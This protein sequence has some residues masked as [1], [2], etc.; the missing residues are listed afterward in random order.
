MK[1]FIQLIHP[2]NWLVWLAMGLL[3]LLTL[4]PF[5]LQLFIGKQ[6]GRLMYGL[7]PSRR[8]VVEI[9]ISLCFP[10][11]SRQEQR[12]LVK[13]NFYS[14]GMMLPE[15][16]LSWW[17]SDRRL[18]KFVEIE[19]LE[20][21]QQAIEK[22]NGALLLGAHYSAME[23]GAR[24]LAT[25]MDIPI[26]VMYRPPKNAVV[27]MLIRRGRGRFVDTLLPRDDI[28]GLIKSLKQNKAVWYAPDQVYQDKGWEMVP[29]F[30]VPAATNLRTSRIVKL[31]KTQV[32]SF[33]T[34]RKLDGSGYKLT[35]QAPFKDFPSGNDIVDATRIHQVF[36]DNIRKNPDQYFWIH[37][38][39]KNRNDL[40]LDL[41]YQHKNY[42]GNN[43]KN[44]TQ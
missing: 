28:R 21:L 18:K 17:S 4:L 11:M 42:H 8:R 9:N 14:M 44:K 1:P 37:K 5:R 23:I 35:L 16:G 31:T 19:G 40:E 36:E 34:Q 29:F 38:R 15:I 3:R 39:F 41:Y 25:Q 22:G 2:K 7:F 12:V 43:D 20:H 26:C 10:E 32:I 24:L 13:Q 6:L 27:E 33:Y 30:G